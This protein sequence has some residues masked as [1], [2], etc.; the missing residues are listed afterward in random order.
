[1][2]KVDGLIK[3]TEIIETAMKVFVEN[4]Y[5]GTSM[6]EVALKSGIA[7]GTIYLYFKNKQQLFVEVIRELMRRFE[8]VI[9]DAADYKS[10]DIYKKMS[11]IINAMLNFIETNEKYFNMMERQFHI[12]GKTIKKNQI[13]KMNESRIKMMDIFAK[14]V[15]EGI[16]KKIFRKI[17]PEVAALVLFTIIT[18]FSKLNLFTTGKK[19]VKEKSNEIMEFFMKGV[20]I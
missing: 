18:A 6:D 8:I 14:I 19:A 12:I 5:D 13:E 2:K 11:H 1:M 17:N 7:K 10:E 9:Y 15:R 16:E 20:G 3:K 4:D